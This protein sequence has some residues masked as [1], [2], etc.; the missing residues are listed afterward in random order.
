MRPHAILTYE[1]KDPSNRTLFKLNHTRN[2]GI[3][4]AFNNKTRYFNNV[5]VNQEV[6]KAQKKLTNREIK[7]KPET[8]QADFIPF[9]S[10]HVTITDKIPDEIHSPSFNYNNF[11]QQTKQKQQKELEKSQQNEQAF[12]SLPK[13]TSDAC[14]LVKNFKPVP[15]K[16]EASIYDD[17]D[18]EVDDLKLLE[19]YFALYADRFK[20]ADEKMPKWRIIYE[21]NGNLDT[22][23]YGS[24][25]MECRVQ[26][27]KNLGLLYSDQNKSILNINQP[28]N[29]IILQY[30]SKRF[31]SKN[32][33]NNNINIHESD[34][35]IT[36]YVKKEDLDHFN[37][38]K[39]CIYIPGKQP[40]YV[41]MDFSYLPVCR[42]IKTRSIE[43]TKTEQ[44]ESIKTE[45]I[46]PEITTIQE[47]QQKTVTRQEIKNRLFAKSEALKKKRM[48]N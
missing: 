43:S 40:L 3:S 9:D 7:P 14:R 19:E 37:N 2:C 36:K 42:I 35:I 39:S 27:I 41:N 5:F 21:R 46:L 30:Q 22:I 26:N 38:I 17:D 48:K 23:F 47:Q 25:R 12:T 33:N 16:K 13:E 31:K 24:R 15:P 44:I 29:K 32:I 34:S 18:E 28:T 6:D 20:E 4:K 45:Q 10:S 1:L 11:V 8:L